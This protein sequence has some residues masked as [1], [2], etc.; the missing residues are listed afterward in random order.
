MPLSHLLVKSFLTLRDLG[1]WLLEILYQML[2]TWCCHCFC[3][4]YP[5]GYELLEGRNYIWFVCVSQC[6]LLC[7]QSINVGWKNEWM[8][9]TLFCCS[10]QF[11]PPSIDSTMVNLEFSRYSLSVCRVGQGVDRLLNPY[12]LLEFSW[13]LHKKAVMFSL[14]WFPVAAVTNYHK[15]MAW[16][17]GNLFS[18]SSGGW[19]SKISITVLKSRSRQRRQHSFRRL[20]AEFMPCFFQLLGVAGIP[21]LVAPSLQVLPL[22]SQCL[23]LVCLKSHSASLS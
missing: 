20:W 7:L 10:L 9:M 13:A 17:N 2:N 16:N 19:K 5:H 18:Q 14:C 8:T 12:Y 11:G 1:P 23:F 4:R 6:L 22:W 15:W 21:W 3:G